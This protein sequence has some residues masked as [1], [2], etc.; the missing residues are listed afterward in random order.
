MQI[1]IY[2]FPAISELI[3]NYNPVLVSFEVCIVSWPFVINIKWRKAPT[4]SFCLFRGKIG[5]GCCRFN[6]LWHLRYSTA[7]EPFS[8]NQ[9]L[10]WVETGLKFTTLNMN[11]WSIIANTHPSLSHILVVPLVQEDLKPCLPPSF[12]PVRYPFYQAH[13]LISA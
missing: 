10:Q 4:A 3:L 5:V 11:Q 2:S 6:R 12:A 13:S 9:C 8:S 7:W 1:K